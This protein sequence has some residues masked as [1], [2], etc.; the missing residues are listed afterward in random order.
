MADYIYMA[1]AA[2]LVDPQK[3]L[4]DWFGDGVATDEKDIVS[5]FRAAED[6]A[7]SAV[8]F[9]LFT[10]QA[11]DLA[12]I[13][14]RGTTTSWDMLAD[15][16][17]WAAAAL[18]QGIR[19]I[20]PIGEI[21]TPIFSRESARRTCISV[22]FCRYLKL[23]VDFLF[24]L[25]TEIVWWLNGLQGESLKKVSFYRLTSQFS[26]FLQQSGNWSDVQV[27]GHSLG[28]GECIIYTLLLWLLFLL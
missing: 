21:W 18:M 7:N 2:Y 24:S 26:E 10:F 19:V 22:A 15:A 6:E 13:S 17:L 16:Q 9:K 14:I 11:Q 4:N 28:G 23:I 25:I 5:N 12:I 8:F 27:T 3:A 20:L 1:G